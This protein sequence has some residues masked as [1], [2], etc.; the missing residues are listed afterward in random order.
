ME[1]APVCAEKQVQ[2]ARAPCPPI[3]K[4][5]SNACFALSDG[6]K[7]IYSGECKAKPKPDKPLIPKEKADNPEGDPMCKSWDDGCNICSRSSVGGQAFCTMR[8]CA[9]GQKQKARCLKYFDETQEPSTKPPRV[10]DLPP[11]PM[12]EPGEIKPILPQVGQAQRQAQQNGAEIVD[13]N[14]QNYA[15]DTELKMDEQFYPYDD[16]GIYL[17]IKDGDNFKDKLNIIGF[18]LPLES[19]RWKLFEGSAGQVILKDLSFKQIASKPLKLDPTWMQDAMAGK[20]VWFDAGFN[21]SNLAKGSYLLEFKNENPSGDPDKDASFVLNIKIETE[22]K[23]LSVEE[24]VKNRFGDFE[25]FWLNPDKNELKIEKR[26]TGKLLG[27]FK[28]DYKEELVLDKDM[29]I[30]KEKK[31]PWWAI[32]VF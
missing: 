24:K 3:L 13:D 30:V 2:C 4:T 6:A 9:D 22:Q 25:R 29:L 27:L 32:L 10:F 17:N 12:D 14:L 26:K 7:I 19:S 28:V 5:Y 11:I 8:Y 16:G 15:A 18:I 21:V 20:K 31:R 23:E 1:Y